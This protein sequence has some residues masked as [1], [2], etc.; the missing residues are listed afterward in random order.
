MAV[1]RSDDVI[2]TIVN[3]A[4][5]MNAAVIVIGNR[6]TRGG[7]HL[8]RMLQNSMPDLDIRTVVTE[9]A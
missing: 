6:P 4:R 9:E 2:P 7:N 3:Y 5:K 1:L 8:T